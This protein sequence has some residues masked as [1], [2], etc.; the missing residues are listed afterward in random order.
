M[1]NISLR[2]LDDPT[3]SRIK[4]NARRRKVSVNRLIVETLREHYAPDSRGFDDLD[5]LAGSWSSAEAAAFETAVA[6]F[7]EIDA[8]LW[9]PREKPAVRGRP[10]AK[11]RRSR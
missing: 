5:A 8:A 3:L 10:A 2:G 9:P 4:T 7:A 6:P 11:R 1:A